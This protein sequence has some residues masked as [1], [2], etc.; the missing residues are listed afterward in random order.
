MSNRKKSNTTTGLVLIFIGA[1]LLA[2][3]VFPGLG[4]WF[5]F[6]FTWPMIIIAIALANLVIGLLAG[7]PDTA[8][9]ACVIGGIGGILYFQTIG[10]LT[11]QSW[12]YM[13]TLIPGFV[14]V[15]MLIAG[16]LK[17]KRKQIGEG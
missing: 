13:W 6:T 1:V 5:H 17:R 16:L 9:S 12:A 10:V 15:G 3:Q 4:A 2:L 7:D 14:G 11:W 8:I